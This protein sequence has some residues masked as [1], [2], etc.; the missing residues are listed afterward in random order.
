ME[1]A[2]WIYPLLFATGLAAGLVDSIAGG[3]G[4]VALPVLLTLGLSAPVALGTNK[5]QSL[6]GTSS[7]SRHYI[8]RG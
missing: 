1:F 3:G 5:F 6:C 2:F 8:R 7:A 4:L